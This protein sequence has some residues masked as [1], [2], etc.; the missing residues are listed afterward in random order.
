VTLRDAWESEARNWLAW[1]RSPGHDSYWRFH[2]DRFLELL[3]PPAGLTLD[4]GCGEGR[5]PRDLKARGYEVVG[6][7]ASPTLIHHAR[8]ADPDGDYRVADAAALPFDDGSVALATTFMA[9]H[10]IDDMDGAVA[11]IARVLERGGCLCAAV[12]H[13]INS[14]GKFTSRDPDAEFVIRDS[15]FEER[16]YADS[17]ERDGLPMTFASRHRSLERLF[18]ALHTAGLLVERL[19]EPADSS[20]PRGSRWQRLPLFLDFR[21]V[22][23]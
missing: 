23:P 15:Y 5:L 19:L 10:D 18:D 4:V 21:A 14:A 12:L 6:I 3:P 7:D 9:L 2:R 16:R 1:A 20:A 17:V 11:E 22:K 13:P 8:A